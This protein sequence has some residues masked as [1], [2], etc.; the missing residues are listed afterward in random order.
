MS[1][2]AREYVFGANRARVGICASLC[3]L[4]GCNREQAAGVTGVVNVQTDTDITKRMVNME[5]L[6]SGCCAVCAGG[7][8]C[9]GVGRSA[10]EGFFFGAGGRWVQGAGLCVRAVRACCVCVL[11]LIGGAA[12]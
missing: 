4:V 1:A 6:F 5:V 9:L 7:E 8:A 3:V 12:T 11:H 2:R 10:L